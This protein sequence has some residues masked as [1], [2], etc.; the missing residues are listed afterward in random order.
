MGSFIFSEN[1]QRIQKSILKELKKDV[2]KLVSDE[3]QK[4]DE[5]IV[6]KKLELKNDLEIVASV[7]TINDHVKKV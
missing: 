3:K 1:F 4:F 7:E 2:D 6:A 5:Y